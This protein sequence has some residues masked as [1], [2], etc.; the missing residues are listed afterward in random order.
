[1]TA[2]LRRQNP[3]WATIDQCI[4]ENA[5]CKDWNVRSKVALLI[6]SIIYGDGTGVNPIK[7]NL[8]IQVPRPAGEEEY[9]DSSNRLKDI[10][11]NT[12]TN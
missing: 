12:S 9:R 2:V 10:L 1:M 7:I 5:K 6:L 4:G 8:I 11:T 3:A